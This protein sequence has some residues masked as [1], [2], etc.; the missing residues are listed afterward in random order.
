MGKKN[1]GIIER[2]S[3]KSIVAAIITVLGF[4]FGVPEYI[5]N[6]RPQFVALAGSDIVSFIEGAILGAITVLL[7]LKFYSQINSQKSTE[8]QKKER[9]AKALRTELEEIKANRTDSNFFTPIYDSHRSQLSILE[10]EIQRAVNRAYSKIKQV[11]RILPEQEWQ[12]LVETIKEAIDS[13]EKIRC[14]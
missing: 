11:L 7:V 12:K 5:F 2:L 9:L 1:R 14:D 8:R 3:W 10:P 13:L 6:I 4:Y